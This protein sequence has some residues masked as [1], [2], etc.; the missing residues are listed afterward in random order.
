MP[1]GIITKGIGGFYYIKCGEDSYE[2]RARGVFRK[3][4]IKPVPGDYVDFSIIDKKQRTGF[5]ET[6]HERKSWLYR[7]MVA[8]VDMLVVVVAVR[9]PEPDLMLADKLLVMSAFNGIDPAVC[10]NKVDLDKDDRCERL[11]GIYKT[12]GYPVVRT[13]CKVQ[14]GIDEL[15]RL[16]EGK[17]TVF[18]GQSGVGKSTLLNMITEDTVMKTGELS[19]KIGKGRHT[20]RHSQLVELGCGGYIVDTPGF[21]SMQ[22]IGPESGE[23][24]YYYPEFENLN[25]KCRF[26]GCTHINEPDCSVKCAL[27]S[28]LISEIRYKS[29]VDLYNTLKQKSEG[30]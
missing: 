3:R 15:F 13:S 6:I 29:Y 11:I 10:I 22:L 23:L 18:A 27:E 21:S 1:Y 25:D 30:I 9:L 24:K 7:P 16:M 28:R 26:K 12:A 17:V 5:L 19:G 2:C 8:N 20:T 4:G 14:R